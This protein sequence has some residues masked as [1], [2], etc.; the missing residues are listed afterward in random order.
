M[1]SQNCKVYCA[2]NYDKNKKSSKYYKCYG[3]SGQILDQ[4][5]RFKDLQAN[6]NKYYRAGKLDNLDDTDKLISDLQEEILTLST[7]TKP[8]T[9]KT[10]QT[11]QTAKK[12]SDLEM[13]HLKSTSPDFHL[14]EGTGN[15]ICLLGSSKRGKSTLMVEIWKRYYSDDKKLI[16]VLISPSCHIPMF[17]NL[18]NVIKIN[19]FGADTVQ[20]LKDVKRIQNKTEN[21]Y[22]FLFMIDD[23]VDSKYCSILNQ[24]ILVMRNSHVST[25]ISLQY[26]K[27]LSKQC[28]SSINN[29]VLFGQNTDESIEGCLK[30]F[31]G[32]E[33]TKITGKKNEELVDLFR[34]LTDGDLTDGEGGAGHAF[35]TYNP[36]SRKIQRGVLDM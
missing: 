9:A 36:M 11:A 13:K 7:S 30:S 14:D 26:D 22:K 23:C 4:T 1:Q 10:A 12:G 27:L 3:D 5:R 24:M 29:V 34:D 2:E 35:L 25:I 6:R 31:C 28:R 33:L 17:K 16:T 32:S 20:L 21:S 18:K 19:K 8:D 15:T